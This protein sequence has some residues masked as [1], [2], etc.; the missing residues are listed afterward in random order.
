MGAFLDITS[1]NKRKQQH[2]QKRLARQDCW[3]HVSSNDVVTV[4]G[5]LEN[6]SGESV[7]VPYF[8]KRANYY[9][10]NYAGGFTQHNVKENTYVVYPSGTVKKARDFGLFVLYPI[11]E[12]GATIKVTEDVKIKRQKPEPVDWTRVLEST[13]TKISAL[14]SLY[15]LYLSRQ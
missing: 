7:S 12:P 5:A 3:S 8:G 6:L 13:V 4:T 9:V 2:I 11:V 10:N 15:I 1:L 14:A